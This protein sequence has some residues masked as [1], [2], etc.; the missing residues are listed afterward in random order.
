MSKIKGFYM[1]SLQSV[2]SFVKIPESAEFSVLGFSSV[3]NFVRFLLLCQL[4]DKFT[5]L[6]IASFKSH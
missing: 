6:S 3:R 4:G 1:N 2:F 5:E